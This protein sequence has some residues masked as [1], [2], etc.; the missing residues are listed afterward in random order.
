MKNFK[1]TSLIVGVLIAASLVACGGAQAAAGDTL[2]VTDT[3]ANGTACGASIAGTQTRALN[4][5]NVNNI[6]GAS[7]G[8]NQ[9]TL[10]ATK[11]FRVSAV[12]SANASGKTQAIITNATVAATYLG[13]STVAFTGAPVVSTVEAIIATGAS[14]EAIQLDQYTQ[15]VRA[16]DGLGLAASSGNSEVCSRVV[17]TEL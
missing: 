4:T 8:S 5:V 9:I 11:K 10:P 12:A 3:K 16:T 6:G 14:A 13:T 15:N 1:F 17:V 7:L 2:I